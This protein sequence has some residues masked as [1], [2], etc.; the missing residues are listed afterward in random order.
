MPSAVQGASPASRLPGASRPGTFVAPGLPSSALALLASHPTAP[1]PCC[2]AAIKPALPR[3]PRRP[4]AS[5]RRETESRG[6]PYSPAASI[7]PGPL[8]SSLGRLG[9]SLG[10][11]LWFGVASRGLLA[12]S[13]SSHV[14]SWGGPG[15]PTWSGSFQKVPPLPPP[16][17]LCCR[18]RGRCHIPLK[19]HNQEQETQR[20][21]AEGARQG[22]RRGSEAGAGVSGGGIGRRRGN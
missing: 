4:A 20:Q 18:E 21:R 12:M 6:W 9:P 19:M 15:G 5:L 16:P 8:G 17:F 13:G 22:Q 3:Q 14:W 1:G 7:P 11:H 2:T 10:M